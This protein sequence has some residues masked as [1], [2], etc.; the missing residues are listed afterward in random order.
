M[1]LPLLELSLPSPRTSV[2]SASWG[3][4]WCNQAQV[5]AVHFLTKEGFPPGTRAQVI[6]ENKTLGLRDEGV[7][8]L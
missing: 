7:Q 8:N 6:K 5:V 3:G 4:W 2:V 1:L